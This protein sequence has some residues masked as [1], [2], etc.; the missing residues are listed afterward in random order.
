LTDAEALD[1]STRLAAVISAV[2]N[3]EAA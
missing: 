1:A 2:M 3:N